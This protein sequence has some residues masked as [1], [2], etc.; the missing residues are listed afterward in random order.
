MKIRQFPVDKLSS[1]KKGAA[2][3]PL[4]V[5]DCLP[6][7]AFVDRNIGPMRRA[8]VELARTADLLRG[9]E[10]IS[11][12]CATQPTVRASAKSAVNIVVGKPIADRITPE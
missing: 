11:F 3:R 5:F 1:K 6:G 9:V 10:I 12:H 8:G 7:L 4:F 2:E